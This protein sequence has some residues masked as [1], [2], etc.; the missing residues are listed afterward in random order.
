MAVAEVKHTH[1]FRDP[2]HVFI[3]LDSDERRI[4]DSRPFQRLRHIHQLATSFL[5]FLA[6][7]TGGSSIHSES[8]NSQGWSSTR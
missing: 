5:I 7:P 2:I 8:C 3:T 4:V 1:E 6:R